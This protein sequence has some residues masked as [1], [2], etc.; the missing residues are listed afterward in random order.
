MATAL[1]NN[2]QGSRDPA[3]QP[4]AIYDHA[5]ALVSQQIW[6]WGRDIHRPQGNWLLETG[7]TRTPPPE[8][9]GECPSRYTLTLHT[10]QTILLRGFGVFFADPKLGCI[11]LPRYKFQ[12]LFTKRSTLDKP[13]WLPDDLPRMTR[14]S[15][16]K[17]KACDTMLKDLVEW[18]WRYEDRVAKELGVAYRE[19]TLLDWDDGS[20][21][22][23]QAEDF[24]QA[25]CALLLDME[26]GAYVF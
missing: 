18:V 13:L 12:P 2:E 26:A 17:R 15:R 9:L 11:Y 23:V 21:P 16:F 7:F 3:G 6:C 20:R 22:C 5:A 4:G 14:P 25:W 10:G 1:D 8:H 19:E 24:A